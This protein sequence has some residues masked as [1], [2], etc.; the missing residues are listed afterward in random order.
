[1]YLKLLKEISSAIKNS[2]GLVN[3][4]FSPPLS[5]TLKPIGKIQYSSHVKASIP[6]RNW[7]RFSLYWSLPFCLIKVSLTTFF[8]L[9]TAS[10]SLESVLFYNLQVLVLF[11]FLKTFLVVCYQ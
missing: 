4:L 10:A 8:M 3:V 6:S 1:M 7:G 2:T 5:R 11:P 9:L